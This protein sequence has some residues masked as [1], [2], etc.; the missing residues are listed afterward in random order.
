MLNINSQGSC[1]VRM[2]CLPFIRYICMRKPWIYAFSLMYIQHAGNI[3][4]HMHVQVS[5]YEGPAPVVP[6]HPATLR[7]G[8]GLMERSQLTFNHES[9]IHISSLI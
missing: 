3:Y 2:Q 9:T 1:S 8:P 5:G 4:T 7:Q 6:P